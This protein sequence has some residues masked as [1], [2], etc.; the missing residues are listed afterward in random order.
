M[1]NLAF[2]GCFGDLSISEKNKFYRI[3]AGFYYKVFKKVYLS[4]CISKI[5]IDENFCIWNIDLA[6]L[7][8]HLLFNRKKLEKEISKFM[9]QYNISSCI[10]SKN[11]KDKYNL[12][13][14]EVWQH[15]GKVLFR[16]VIKEIV[17]VICRQHDLYLY[18]TEFCLISHRCS[19]EVLRLAKLFSQDVR[20][21]TVISPDYKLIEEQMDQLSEEYGL[22]VRVTDD[23]PTGY[24][25]AKIIISVDGSI[26]KNNGK[27]KNIFIIN[28]GNKPTNTIRADI[29]DKA[30]IELPE[31]IKYIKRGF[32]KSTYTNQE[33][34]E[35]IILHKLGIEKIEAHYNISENQIQQ[36]SGTFIK[37]GYIVKKVYAQ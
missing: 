36:I 16:A 31:N 12:S 2:V 9:S 3:I 10:S 33:L 25:K 4:D 24:E 5:D 34:A 7:Y 15:G 35:I 32:L 22:S 13:N 27:L 37:D 19:D 30:E 6:D 26:P 23:F 8:K 21:L 28:L 11:F 1:G 20:F 14:C 18:N 17:N 29:I